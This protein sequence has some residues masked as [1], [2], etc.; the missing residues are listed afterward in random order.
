VRTAHRA[1]ARRHHGQDERRVGNFNAHV[2]A[3]PHVDWPDFSA[4]FVAS[5]GLESNAYTTQTSRTIGSRSIAM[6]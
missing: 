5:L 3:F 4:R 6:R 1:H 2:A